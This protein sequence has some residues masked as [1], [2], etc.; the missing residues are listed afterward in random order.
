[1]RIC[2]IASSRF[3]VAEPFAGGLE[4]HTHTLARS[5]QAR[6]HT[7]SL[8]AAPGSDPSLMT[9]ALDVERFESSAEARADVG[10]PPE[11]WMREH[12]AYLGLMM[13]LAR[14]GADRFDVVH[15]NSLHHLPVAM[16]ELLDVPMVTTL[17]TPPTVWLESAVRFAPSTTF[18]A[19]SRDTAARW[20]GV[21]HPRVILNGVDTE[22]WSFGPG[23]SD[24]V[25][26]GRIVP[27]KAPH[28]A[29]DA[30]RLAGMR[31]QL[32]GP[33]HD[34]GYFAREIEPRLGDDIRYVGHLAV[35]ELAALVGRSAVAVVTPAW[36][37]P[38]GLVAA[39]AMACGTP[40]A[41]VA[42]GALPELVTPASGRLAP[43]G[44]LAALA[45]AMQEAAQLSRRETR[46]HALE[47]CSVDT[48]VDSYE[49]LYS[50]LSLEVC[51][52]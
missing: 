52:A 21:A 50:E 13:E 1:M 39:E 7:V 8:F 11:G 31:L 48:M 41:A 37:E 40:I 33:V 24:A 29:I 19:V 12:H 45:V 49:R 15:N 25:W 3:P 27:E 17:H 38:Y 42:V 14:T 16:A 5:L 32:A 26:F 30:A 22:Q 43:L 47:H 34:P 18:A 2:I 10:A 44:D 46:R 35:E 51:A 4:A 20:E 28:V 6:G 9:E 36:P 23:G